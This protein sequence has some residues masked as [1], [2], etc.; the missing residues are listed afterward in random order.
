MI[1]NYIFDFGQVIA[2]FNT[3]HLTSAHVKEPENIKIIEKVVFDRLYW[4]KL[5]AGTITDE[6]V[7]EGIC[8]RLPKSLQK[9]A[10]EVYDN[11]HRN[12]KIIDGIPGLLQKIKEKGGKLFLLSN[13]STGFAENYSSVS[14]L[15]ELLSMFDG[16]VFSGVIGMT[17][18]NEDIFE[19]LLNK[20]NLKTD[21]C[22]FIDD[23]LNNVTTARN[24]GINAY[25]FDGNVSKLEMKLFFE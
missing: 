10:C 6:K 21:E 2:E 7:K 25:Q 22:I 20:Y 1:K 12:M 24:L 9:E 11:W 5:D 13:I 16:L 4:D 15:K 8:S 14:E 17:K 19:Y 23:N 3:E 18:P